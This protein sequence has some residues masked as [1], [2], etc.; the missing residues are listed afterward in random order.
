MAAAAYPTAAPPPHAPKIEWYGEYGMTKEE[1]A[2]RAT[3]EG[4][5]AVVSDLERRGR[6]PPPPPFL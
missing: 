3:D 2:A 4:E 1:V 5:F 6:S